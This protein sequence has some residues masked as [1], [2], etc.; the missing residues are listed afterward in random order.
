MERP[1]LFPCLLFLLLGCALLA[2]GNDG[3]NSTVDAAG[4]PARME[5]LLGE[6]A[7]D[8]RNIDQEKADRYVAEAENYATAHRGDTSAVYFLFKA[9]EV[10]TLQ[11]KYD[12]AINLYELIESDF[13]THPRAPQALFMQAFT[14][15]ENLGQEDMAR[16]TYE[17]FINK[18]P[19]HDFADDAQVMLDNLGKTDEEILR[20][21]EARQQAAGQEKQ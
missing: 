20:E 6:V 9:A 2:C 18:Y 17:A 5:T 15:D 11:R 7:A 13:S 8:P 10:A 21:L 19:D 12:K 1:P 14:Y 4:F 3:S 16:Q